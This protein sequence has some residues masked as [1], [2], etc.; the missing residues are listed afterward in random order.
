MG[1]SSGGTGYFAPGVASG[2][3]IVGGSGTRDDVPILAM[4]GE[5]MQPKRA[6]RYY[7]EGVMEA[8]RR[9]MIPREIFSNLAMDLKPYRPAYGFEAGGM[10]TGSGSAIT[11]IVEVGGINLREKNNRLAAELRS[12][13][14]DLILRKLKDYSR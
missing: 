6:V 2:G 1:G 14:E 3:P 12:D 5:F 9:L 13:I 4:G 10:V 7:G 8:L 11:N